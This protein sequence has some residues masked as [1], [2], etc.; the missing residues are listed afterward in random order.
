[1]NAARS[2]YTKGEWYKGS[3][4]QPGHD[5]VF[6]GRDEKRHNQKRAQMAPGVCGS[7]NFLLKRMHLKLR[8]TD[9]RSPVLRERNPS[10]EGSIDAQLQ[11][12]LRLIRTKYLSTATS[13]AGGLGT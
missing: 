12:L 2:P 10:L 6:S 9:I 7:S 1:M 5:N 3:R 13:F 4:I 8:I 11:N